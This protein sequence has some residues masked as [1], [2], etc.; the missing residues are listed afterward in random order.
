[1]ES[2]DTIG[3]YFEKPN[4]PKS[5]K[6]N[7]YMP[8]KDT[9]GGNLFIE[10]YNVA[11][12][13]AS[14]HPES[15]DAIRRQ[16]YCLKGE[17]SHLR[18]ADLGNLKTGNEKALIKDNIHFGLQAVI[19]ELSNKNIFCIVFSDDQ[20]LTTAMHEG[21]ARKHNE[22]SLCIIDARLDVGAKSMKEVNSSNYL[23]S[24]SES[25]NLAKCNILAHQNYYFSSS[26]MDFLKDKNFI[27]E[28]YR[29]GLIRH[30][31]FAAEPVLRDA[32]L[33]SL[34]LC[35]IR[36]SDSPQTI[37][38]S[39]NGL[40]G[41]ECCQLMRYAGSSDSLSAIGVF[42]FEPTL[43]ENDQ[44]ANITAQIIWHALEG[45]D[46]RI[47]DYPVK[48]ISDYKKYIIPMHE[49]LTLRFFYGAELDRWW[50]MIP[51]QNGS[52]IMA[53]SKDD[54]MEA[55]AGNLPGIWLRYFNK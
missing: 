49:D 12:I 20:A 8:T 48:P 45:L 47:G 53:C 24:L 43:R 3:L 6:P 39:P 30:N 13:G 42:G 16:L 35:A 4:F 29:L 54:F 22:M 9:I 40:T 41:E 52:Q 33:L 50:T 34:D 2:A 10:D 19:D 5:F 46:N 37:N 25:E 18:I 1:M 36:Q 27:S 38:P 44:T 51:T 14:S 7:K 21:L 55:Q 31:T 23:F 15:V 26:Q 28:E 11:I 32:H 17:F